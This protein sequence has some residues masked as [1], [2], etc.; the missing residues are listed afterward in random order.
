[1]LKGSSLSIARWLVVVL[2]ELFDLVDQKFLR[3]VGEGWSRTSALDADGTWRG[4]AYRKIYA[5]V[6]DFYGTCQ[7]I[8]TRE[9]RVRARANR[10]ACTRRAV[11]CRLSA[12]QRHCDW[13]AEARLG[14]K[15]LR[16]DE[17]DS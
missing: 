6:I 15:P 13:R 9:T 12:G 3:S 7:L 8:V 2:V 11:Q 1:M 5:A 4:T 17:R 14:A 10:S 16:C